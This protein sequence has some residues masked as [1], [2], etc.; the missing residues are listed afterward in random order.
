M[1]F[2]PSRPWSLETFLQASLVGQSMYGCNHF[3][4]L[5][6][7]DGCQRCNHAVVYMHDRTVVTRL[8]FSRPNTVTLVTLDIFDN[9]ILVYPSEVLT[10][11]VNGGQW[12][13]L[14]T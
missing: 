4:K 12:A 1:Q 14:V 11:F 13:H 8:Y 6:W 5:R 7:L 10:V 3:G 2:S 9:P